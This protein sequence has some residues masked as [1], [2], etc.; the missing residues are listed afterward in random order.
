M[1]LPKNKDHEGPAYPNIHNESGV[2]L[3]EVDESDNT[4]HIGQC[5]ESHCA[6]T[7]KCKNCGSYEFKVGVGSYY[8]AIS[9]VNCKWE[10]AI[11]E[12]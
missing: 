9:C 1:T 7:I 6:K 12:G 8:T 3:F 11:H 5:Y 2:K 10:L 4:F